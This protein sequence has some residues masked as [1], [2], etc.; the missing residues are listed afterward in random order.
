MHVSVGCPP[1]YE[2]DPDI[3]KRAKAEGAQ[4]GAIIEITHDPMVA[5]KNADAIYTDVWISMGQ[6]DE[7]K[8]R[9]AAFAPYQVNSELM[10]QAKS[11]AIVLHC[12]PAHRGE[13]ITADVLDGPQSVVLDQAENR[14]H[15][16][17][18]I[19]LEWLGK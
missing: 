4:T 14:L 1:G 15:I 7:H 18:A 5:A 13:E 8:P 6:E 12:L 2:P 9:M 17:K 10:K 3:V 11:R 19:L 16:Q